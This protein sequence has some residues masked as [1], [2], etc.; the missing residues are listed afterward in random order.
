M[1]IQVEVEVEVEVENQV[2]VQMDVQVEV[3]G[4]GYLGVAMVFLCL[5]VM[6]PPLEL[7]RCPCLPFAPAAWGME[8][9]QTDG[10]QGDQQPPAPASRGAGTGCR[11][12]C[13]RPTPQGSSRTWGA[14][15]VVWHLQRGFIDPEL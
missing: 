3:E 7:L 8:V 2:Q 12:P 10:K 1:E 13:C 9:G 4:A 14:A 15:A 6:G 5:S 11:T